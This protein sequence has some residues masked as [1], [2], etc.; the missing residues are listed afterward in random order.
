MGFKYLSDSCKRNNLTSLICEQGWEE[1]MDDVLADN[2]DITA[3][4]LKTATM[5]RMLDENLDYG[6]FTETDDEDCHQERMEVRC[7][8][9][10]QV[11]DKWVNGEFANTLSQKH[12]IHNIIHRCNDVADNGRQCVHP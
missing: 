11:A 10:E 7:D 1:T 12:T 2:P 5:Y 8:I 9:C 6:P 3:D 4:D